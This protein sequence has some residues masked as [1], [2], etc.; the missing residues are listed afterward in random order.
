MKT[1]E[2]KEE[3]INSILQAWNVI[4]KPQNVLLNITNKTNKEQ[5]VSAFSNFKCKNESCDFIINDKDEYD[6]MC[7][8]LPAY[9]YE[10][11]LIR[12]Q[13]QNVEQLENHI[14]VYE[15]EFGGLSCSYPVYPLAYFGAT[16][17]QAC[18]VDVPININL[19]GKTQ[20]DT[21]ILPDNTLSLNIYKKS[22]KLFAVSPMR[23]DVSERF[24]IEIFNPT[25]Q[26][27]EIDM[28]FDYQKNKEW[29]EGGD[30]K[31]IA[32]HRLKVKCYGNESFFSLVDILQ[33]SEGSY[34]TFHSIYTRT[35][36]QEKVFNSKFEYSVDGKV[37]SFVLNDIMPLYQFQTNILEFDE[38]SVINS[39]NEENKQNLKFT[40]PSQSKIIFFVTLDGI[41]K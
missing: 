12:I 32:D 3:K 1:A 31:T 29:R 10:T 30:R 15:K 25:G 36:S 34:I 19:N 6:Y 18:I 41:K 16:Q 5:E 4:D 39:F 17:F 28:N 38:K 23:K 37:N 7:K 33:H 22:E 26:D 35:G 9:N 11:G 14:N 24:P 40:I 20:L 21:V 27:I 2:K 8:L 13:T